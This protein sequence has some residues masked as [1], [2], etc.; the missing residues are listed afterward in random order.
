[1]GQDQVHELMQ[2]VE[3]QVDVAQPTDPHPHTTTRSQTARAQWKAA[4]LPRA[5]NCVGRGKPEAT[6][7][8]RTAHGAA[9]EGAAI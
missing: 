6:G 4:G 9:K 8:R 1:M 5:S 7:R 3:A 2:S